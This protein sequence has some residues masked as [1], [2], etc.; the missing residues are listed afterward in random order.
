MFNLPK[1]IKHIR[2]IDKKIKPSKMSKMINEKHIISESIDR[3]YRFWTPK[4]SVNKF[5]W[6]L[7]RKLRF[8]KGQPV[9]FTMEAM[10]T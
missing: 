2:F 6:R 9:H 7:C 4:V 10:C 3:F 1:F 8:R 5:K